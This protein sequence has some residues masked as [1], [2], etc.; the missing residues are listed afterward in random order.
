[1]EQQSEKILGLDVSTTTIGTCLY[2]ITNLKLLELNR[3]TPKLNK[4]INIK[5]IHKLILKAEVFGSF[6]IKYRNMNIKRVIIEEPLLSSNNVYTV[7]IL[8]RFNGII[9]K[10]CYDILGIIPEYISTSDSR[11]LAFP[12]LVQK[13]LGV[14]GKLSAKP[15]LFGGFPL[16]INGKKID[17]KKIIW[18]KVSELEPEVNWFTKN[19]K[20]DKASYDASDAYCCVRAILKREKIL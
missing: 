2:D 11:R 9:S 19:G 13:R 1:M 10:M 20:L 12:E 15:T 8:L 18:E 5:E 16:K 17:K 7:A 6:I 3:I 14:N 4:K